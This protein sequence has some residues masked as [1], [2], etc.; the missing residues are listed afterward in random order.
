MLANVT[1]D[2]DLQ[3][4]NDITII[5]H[6]ECAAIIKLKNAESALELNREL[7]VA[8]FSDHKGPLTINIDGSTYTFTQSVWEG[9]LSVT[10][11]WLDKYSADEYSELFVAEPQSAEIIQLFG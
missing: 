7:T 8:H 4:W 1:I 6:G 9:I 3:D 5:S 2:Y 10:D 11:Q